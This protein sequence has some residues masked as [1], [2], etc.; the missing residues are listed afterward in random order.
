MGSEMCIRDSL[1]YLD[2]KVP[3]VHYDELFLR[4]EDVGDR[5]LKKITSYDI[6]GYKDLLAALE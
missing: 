2:S 4:C 6:K 1:K 3:K 5:D